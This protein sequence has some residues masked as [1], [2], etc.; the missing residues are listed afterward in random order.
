M[1]GSA[2]AAV[3]DRLEILN[4]I[5][6][7]WLNKAAENCSDLDKN[8]L[9]SPCCWSRKC[10]M[11][12]L[13]QYHYRCPIKLGVINKKKIEDVVV[14]ASKGP[15]CYCQ[16]LNPNTSSN[17]T[18]WRRRWWRRVISPSDSFSWSPRSRPSK[19]GECI[20]CFAKF[21]SVY[22]DDF[23]R[24][25]HFTSPPF[26][27]QHLL[28]IPLPHLKASS[29]S[30]IERQVQRRSAREVCL[31]W[32]VGETVPLSALASRWTLHR[33]GGTLSFISS[34]GEC[35]LGFGNRLHY[36]SSLRANNS[37]RKNATEHVQ[38]SFLVHLV[39]QPLGKWL[40]RGSSTDTLSI[41]DW[42]VTT[43]TRKYTSKT[44]L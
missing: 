27:P 41:R 9:F 24:G 15:I 14:D 11:S 30:V 17:C 13:Q 28:S 42:P 20:N 26:S 21:L 33:G 6:H 36:Y 19:K 3:M 4:L 34:I 40:T 23:P 31:T 29:Q 12:M 25:S 1:I 43:V 2:L 10:C 44:P 22:I 5:R 7:S 8:G 16:S 39:S 35:N 32:Y 18:K 38:F 37:R